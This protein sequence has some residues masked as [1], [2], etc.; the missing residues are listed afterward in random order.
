MRTRNLLTCIA[1]LLGVAV[2]MQAATPDGKNCSTAY[3]LTGD[4]PTEVSANQT[5]WY[6]AWTFDLPLAVY[7]I[8]K[9]GKS[10]PPPEAEMDFTL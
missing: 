8:P 2:S 3:P 4:Y 1:F 9:N 6:S 5:V 7:F 10:D